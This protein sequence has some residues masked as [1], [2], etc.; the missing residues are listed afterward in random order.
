MSEHDEVHALR[1]RDLRSI[2]VVPRMPLTYR[3]WARAAVVC[4]TARTRMQGV[5][6]LDDASRAV[7]ER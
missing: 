4:G 7:L 1:V 6:G 3:A 2:E 5:T